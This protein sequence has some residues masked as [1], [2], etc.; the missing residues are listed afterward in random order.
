MDAVSAFAAAVFAASWWFRSR[1]PDEEHLV[2][3]FFNVLMG[4]AVAI[5]LLGFVN[6][7]LY[8]P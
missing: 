2:A 3:L 8:L 1:T 7:Q 6:R 5:G 4:L